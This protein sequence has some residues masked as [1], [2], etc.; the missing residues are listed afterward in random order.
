MLDVAPST[1]DNAL[2]AF[3]YAIGGIYEIGRYYILID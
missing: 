3:K 2:L 1:S